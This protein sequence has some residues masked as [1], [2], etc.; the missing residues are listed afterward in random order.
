MTLSALVAPW[1]FGEGLT[2]K[3]VVGVALGVAAMAVLS[4]DT[5]VAPQ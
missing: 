2:V 5:S 1:I 4:L 3:R